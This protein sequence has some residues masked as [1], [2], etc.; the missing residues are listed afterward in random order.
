VVLPSSR[1]P[2]ILG[3]RLLA[4]DLLKRRD[5]SDDLVT[6]ELC[7]IWQGQHRALHMAL[8]HVTTRYHRNP[9]ELEAR[10]AVKETRPM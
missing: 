1:L 2:P 7:H 4:D 3:L 9:Y 5:A 6:H 10:R 8:N